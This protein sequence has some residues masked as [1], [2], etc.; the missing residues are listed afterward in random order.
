MTI[1]NNEKGL[2]R[3]YPKNRLITDGIYKYVQHPLYSFFIFVTILINCLE[4][5]FN[6]FNF[7]LYFWSLFWIIFILIKIYFEEKDLREK[8]GLEYFEY[9][10]K[11]KRFVP[12]II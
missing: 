7:T 4:T 3:F 11:T 8:Y 9:Q 1:L 12:W 2:S 5:L 10:K 6:S